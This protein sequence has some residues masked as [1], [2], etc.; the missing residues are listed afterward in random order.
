MRWLNK[1]SQSPWQKH[2]LRRRVV[3]AAVIFAVALVA[4]AHLA[5]SGRIE[6][7]EKDYA[8]AAAQYSNYIKNGKPGL[9]AQDTYNYE[10][11]TFNKL[12]Y[13]FV[14]LRFP[15]QESFDLSK[16]LPVRQVKQAQ[17][18]VA[19]RWVSVLSGSVA[20]FLLAL[21]N[22]LAG[23]FLAVHTYAIKYS[24]VIYLDALPMCAALLAFQAFLLVLKRGPGKQSAP[25][26]L[27]S[28]IALGVAAASKYMYA[29]VGVVLVLYS[30]AW[31][32][33]KR[34][35][36][37][38]YLAIWGIIAL[39]VFWAADPYLWLNPSQRLLASL[40]FNVDFA[41]GP[42][43]KFTAYPRWQPFVWL[44]RPMP[45]YPIGRVTPFFVQPRDFWLAIDSWIFGLGIVGLP[46]M[47]RRYPAYFA[48]LAVGLI[49]LLAW[50]TKWPQYVLLVLPP[51]CLAA[52]EGVR[53]LWTLARIG[54]RKILP[55]ASE[56]AA[57]TAHECRN[58]TARA[59]RSVLCCRRLRRVLLA[60][61]FLL[62]PGFEAQQ[63]GVPLGANFPDPQLK[64][65]KRLG[66]ERIALFAAGLLHGN[67]A[68]RL[69]N[70]E[71]LENT[72]PG[73]RVFLRQ[74]SR[75]L[76]AVLR[77]GAKQAAAHRVGERV[78][79]RLLAF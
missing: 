53:T 69:K 57:N 5:D 7:D 40:K 70:G 74:L 35:Q 45:H 28:A 4:R 61:F 51:L 66:R 54:L 46:L 75:R 71:V 37:V 73:N 36:I 11:P 77:Q 76:R 33:Q 17:E 67:Q 13:A 47:I 27:F 10:H 20:V 50:S 62:E 6:Y 60:S 22:P 30:F 25:W 59:S 14:L 49:F 3:L 8:K 29:L 1:A 43:V 19:M 42:A 58:R 16:P 41:S 38:G 32:I 78:E 23:L 12:V 65:A 21:V 26:L 24:S 2:P 39:L 9:I 48:W 68:R 63:A 55:A 31:M 52:A 15:A 79:E 44:L 72:L 18:V 34:R 64:L 56:E